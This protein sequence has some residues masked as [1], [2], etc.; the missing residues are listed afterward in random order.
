MIKNVLRILLCLIS[1]AGFSLIALNA[2][3]DFPKDELLHKT[4]AAGLGLSYEPSISHISESGA[5]DKNSDIYINLP[6]YNE[7]PLGLLIYDSISLSNKLL[8]GQD[9]QPNISPEDTIREPALPENV[10][11]V[12]AL[13]L[14]DDQT[15]DRITYQNESKYTPD[16]NSLYKSDY[17]LT[18][19]QSVSTGTPKAPLVLIIHTHGTESYLPDGTN[20]Y[21]ADTA[22]RSKNISSNV[23][24]VGKALADE[25]NKKG[26]STI[27]CETMF[28]LE[29]YSDSYNLSEKAICD[30]LAKYPSIK[31]VFDVHRDSVIRENNEKIKTLAVIDG[32]ETAQAMFVVGTD[33]SGADHPNWLDNLTVAVHFQHK[34][35]EDHGNIM[36]PINLRAASFNAEHAPGSILIEIG[37]CGNTISEAKNCATLLGGTIADVILSDG[38]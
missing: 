6:K 33:S 34:L 7:I 28:D 27:H 13:D 25:L 17:P 11:P 12:I 23:V 30:Y 14:S 29:S 32:V 38:K 16:V 10:F 36:R 37:T 24:A 1:L 9:H 21:T 4:V 15:I 8:F 22:T 3:I 31:Y 2:T 18:L 26:V 35:I 20:T 5:A 19:S